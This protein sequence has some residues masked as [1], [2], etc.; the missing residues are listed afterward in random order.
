MKH[1]FRTPLFWVSFTLISLLGFAYTFKFFPTAFPIV[2]ID[3]TTDRDQAIS[4]AQQAAEQHH[5]GPQD[6]STAVSFDSDSKTQTFVELAGGGQDAFREMLKKHHYMPY[7]WHVRRFK[8]FEKNETHVYLT[9]Q[10]KLYGFREKISE[11]EMRPSL[12]KEDALA[13]V[14]RA[15]QNDI[16]IDTKPYK[17][18]EDAKNAQQKLGTYRSNLCI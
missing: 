13:L 11:D 6:S 3:I 7:K 16:G 9:P 2:N 17:L 8:E 12:S 4:L 15:L 14:I 18:I 5:W 1:I 10:G